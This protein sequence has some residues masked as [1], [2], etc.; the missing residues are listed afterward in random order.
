MQKVIGSKIENI[1]ETRKFSCVTTKGVAALAPR[2]RGPPCPGR[3]YL[4]YPCPLAG[5]WTGL[6]I[7]PGKD[8]GPEA[9]GNKHL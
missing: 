4:P 1:I 6:G 2:V 9:R 5:L 7:P 3:R 8:L